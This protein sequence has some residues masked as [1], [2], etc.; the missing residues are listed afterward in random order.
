MASRT[1]DLVYIAAFPQEWL[2]AASTSEVGQLAPNRACLRQLTPEDPKV[3]LTISN[4]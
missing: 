1:A 2:N 3:Q 4:R